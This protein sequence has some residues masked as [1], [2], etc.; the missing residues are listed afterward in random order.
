MPAAIV[1]ERFGARGA[2]RAAR[3][4]CAATRLHLADKTPDT[5]VNT[6]THRSNTDWGAAL[7]N[8]ENAKLAAAALRGALADAV[9]LDDDAF[10]SASALQQYH[11]RLLVRVGEAG[12]GMARMDCRWHERSRHAI[13]Q[14]P[15]QL[16]LVA[17]TH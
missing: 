10:A 13:T 16:P 8:A 2:Q 5:C 4:R 15:S 1:D 11:D 12:E 9:F 3:R 17:H 7:G 14:P 6:T